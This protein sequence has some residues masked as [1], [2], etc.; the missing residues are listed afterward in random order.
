MLLSMILLMMMVGECMAIPA[1]PTPRKIQQPDGTFVTLS[2]HGNEYLHYTTTT[3]G[4]TVVKDERGFWVYASKQADGTLAATDMVAH[5]EADRTA[6]EKSFLNSTP[7]W[8]APVMDSRM[9]ER[10]QSER[11]R[12][13]QAQQ[14]RSA[15]GG[16]I[17]IS[18]DSLYWWNTTTGSSCM[19]RR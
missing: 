17:R 7:R 3:D 19:A 5:D 11:V 4:F 18:A 12:R 6:D 15:E 16:A 8:L 13:V 10:R 1:D 14:T 2:L 9:E